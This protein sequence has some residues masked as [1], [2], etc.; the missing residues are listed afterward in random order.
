[1]S[2]T[3]GF[4]WLVGGVVGMS[5]LG[6]CRAPVDEAD[7]LASEQSIA[8][9]EVAVSL[10]VGK[11]SLSASEDVAVTVTYTNISSEPV[12][13]LKWYVPG[14]ARVQEGLFEVM[15]NG[16]PVEYI[17]PHIKRPA[18]GAEEFVTLAPGESLSG[19]AAVSG[20]YDLT[21][22]GIY[23]VRFAAGSLDQ[24]HVVLTKAAQL[25]SNLLNLWIE[26]RASC[27]SSNAR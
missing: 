16:E 10:S 7:Q 5:L 2:K 4:K 3:L 21:E 20:L 25:D 1:M 17:G 11:S 22:S 8:N 26:G 19:T 15:R 6:A 12:R 13:L 9:G 23:T 14:T 18:P 27:N 24:H